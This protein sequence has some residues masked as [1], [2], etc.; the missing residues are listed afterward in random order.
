[1]VDQYIMLINQPI[2]LPY[3][4]TLVFYPSMG[5]IISSHELVGIVKMDRLLKERLFFEIF[6]KK[7]GT[8]FGSEDPQIERLK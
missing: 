1:M 4:P 7:E 8:I 6:L 5:S 2:Y 3:L